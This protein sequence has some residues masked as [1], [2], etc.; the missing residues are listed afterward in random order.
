MLKRFSILKTFILLTAFALVL[1]SLPVRAQNVVT[2]HDAAT[3]TGAS[4]T[5]CNSY[6]YRAVTVKFVIAGTASVN[7]ECMLGNG[8]PAYVALSGTGLPAS[9]TSLISV[10]TFA[11]AWLRTN[12]AS[13]T[14]CTVSTYCMKW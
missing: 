3:A 14:G 7:L 6:G 10:T 9:A 5:V 8:D 11:C 4:S 2:M 1:A 13:C 12:I